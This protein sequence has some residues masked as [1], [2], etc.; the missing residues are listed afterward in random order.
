MENEVENKVFEVI[1]GK[2]VSIF[3][4]GETKLP[5]KGQAV[6]PTH[7]GAI[8]MGFESHNS[9]WQAI[10]ICFNIQPAF[11][12]GDVVFC[13]DRKEAANVLEVDLDEGKAFLEFNDS[14]DP[15]ESSTEVWFDGRRW[16]FDQPSI[17]VANPPK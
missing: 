13:L 12:A 9:L 7:N 15:G 17:F 16:L 6:V 2:F 5:L 10:V 14:D 4:I 3:E 11:N 1:N 8:F